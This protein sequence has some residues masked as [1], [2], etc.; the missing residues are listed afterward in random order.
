LELFGRLFSRDFFSLTSLQ[1]QPLNRIFTSSLLPQTGQPYRSFR[2]SLESGN[3]A[4]AAERLAVMH[5]Q[6][7]LPQREP[8]QHLVVRQEHR[9]ETQAVRRQQEERRLVD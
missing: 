1:R 5:R 4:A 6:Q 9:A 3:V 2:I 7:A 8:R